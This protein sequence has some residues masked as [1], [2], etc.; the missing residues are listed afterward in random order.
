MPFRERLVWF[1]SNHFTVS[2]EKAL[3]FA[4]VGSFEREAIR[5]HVTGSFT[6]RRQDAGIC[7]RAERAAR[8]A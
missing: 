4:L 7:A 8:P 5:P 2:A 6:E 3:V 1:W